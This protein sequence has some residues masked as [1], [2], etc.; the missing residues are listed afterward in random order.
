MILYN[1]ASFFYSALAKGAQCNETMVL[2]S[3]SENW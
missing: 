2:K 1:W 3:T